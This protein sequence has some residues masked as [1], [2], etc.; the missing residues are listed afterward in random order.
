M[1]R[2]C[3]PPVPTPTRSTE[4]ETPITACI[5]RLDPRAA[6]PEIEIYARGLRNAYGFCWDARGRMIATDNGPNENAP[7]EL[8]LVEHGKH[9]G[10]PYTFANLEK[11]PYPDTPPAPPGLE[12]TPPVATFDAH[13]SPAGVVYLGATFPPHARDSFLV[14]RFGNLLSVPPVG[15][16]LLQVRFVEDRRAEAKPLIAGL[17]RP[18]DIHLT[19][20]GRVFIVEVFRRQLELPGRIWEVSAE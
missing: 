9:Y 7:E 18:A 12:M 2:F 17:T 11:S 8:N 1:R 20:V 4:G 5:W 14:V 13:S 6:K 10:F 15:Q 16:D 3:T 19:S